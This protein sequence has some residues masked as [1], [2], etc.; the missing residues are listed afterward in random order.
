V[1]TPNPNYTNPPPATLPGAIGDLAGA[2]VD[3]AAGM[4]AADLAKIAA[5]W[6]VINGILTP[7][8]PAGRAPYGPIDPTKFGDVG[9]VNLPG[10]NPGFFTN[11]P[12]Q[13]QT[14]SPVQSKFYWGQHPYQTGARFS[15]EQYRQVPAP[16]VPFGLQ[17][18]YTPES[19]SINTL[20]AGVR[21]ASG[22][23]PFNIPQAPRV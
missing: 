7:P 22:Q 15:P 19:Q 17:Q 13:Y 20:L 10:T 2:A 8:M 23:A 12:Q 6:V 21:D 1:A 3:A 5:G 14:T 16:A 11:V 18:M 4:S 9:R